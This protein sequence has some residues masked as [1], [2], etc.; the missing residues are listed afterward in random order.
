MN[1][2]PRAG[3]RPVLVALALVA[4]GCEVPSGARQLAAP[5]LDPHA[6]FADGRR[7]SASEADPPA[8]DDSFE[9]RLRHRT[10][11]ARPGAADTGPG[12]V[13]VQRVGLGSGLAAELPHSRRGWTWSRLGGLTLV[14]HGEP[15]DALIL[16]QDL[17][18]LARRR[19]SA[20]LNRFYLGIDR[21]LASRWVGAGSELTPLV[22]R[23]AAGLPMPRSE[24]R[25]ALELLL[26]PSLGRGLGYVSDDGSF[27]GWR[28]LGRNAGGSYL[29][30]ARTT[31]SWGAQEPL[32]EPVES[33]LGLLA[34]GAP[35][36]SDLLWSAPVSAGDAGRARMVLGTAERDDGSGIHLAI[37]CR[38][39]PGCDSQ[40]DLARFLDSI[41]PADGEALSSGGEERFADLTRRLG[42]VLHAGDQAVDLVLLQRAVQRIAPPAG[43]VGGLRLVEPEPVEEEE[44]EP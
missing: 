43:P 38:L 31:G 21:R 27:T 25:R 3:L 12:P 6:P 22:D 1:R 4:G 18:D 35:E 5:R 37:L 17:S 32:P 19:P 9:E 33:L 23:A 28:W 34:D 30:L 7:T 8:A 20:A 40:Q 24:V 10:A 15:A 29:R 39:R 16:T 11:T 42:L 36:L 13:A 14:A 26:T 2:R 44:E 41:A